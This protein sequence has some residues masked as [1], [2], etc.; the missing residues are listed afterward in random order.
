M[1]V[2]NEHAPVK[3]KSIFLS[4]NW[5]EYYSLLRFL[6]SKYKFLINQFLIK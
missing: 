5:T 1:G 2:L 4:T 3:K 6:P